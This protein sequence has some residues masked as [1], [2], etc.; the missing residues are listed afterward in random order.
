MGLHE[1]GIF[2]RITM[3]PP[4]PPQQ[5]NKKR[6]SVGLHV[7]ALGLFLGKKFA[8]EKVRPWK[9]EFGAY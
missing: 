8:E 9:E 1:V 5:N 3:Q 4:S 7:K 2:A 6:I